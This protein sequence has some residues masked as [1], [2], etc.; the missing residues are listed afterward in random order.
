M[1]DWKP[2]SILYE[3][4]IDGFK[5]LMCKT[6][7][8]QNRDCTLYVKSATAFNFSVSR[9]LPSLEKVLQDTKRFFTLRTKGHEAMLRIYMAQAKGSVE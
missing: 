9:Y 1:S 6:P 2:S 4:E 5:Y 8:T 7:N 3:Y